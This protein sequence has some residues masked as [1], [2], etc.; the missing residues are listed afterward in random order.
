MPV[1]NLT[2][3]SPWPVWQSLTRRPVLFT[4]CPALVVAFGLPLAFALPFAPAFVMTFPLVLCLG[5]MLWRPA[6]ALPLA[7]FVGPLV[8]IQFELGLEEKTASFDKLLLVVI[9]GAWAL[10]KVCLR[11][12]NVPQDSLLVLWWSWLAVL[13][14][15]VALTRTHLGNQLWFMAEQLSYLLFFAICLDVLRDPLALR[16]SVQAIVASG[17][18]VVLLGM[19]NWVG[20]MVG[21]G[22]IPLTYP[23]TDEWLYSFVSTIGQPNFYSAYQ[24][25][26][27]PVA[28]WI[29]WNSHGARRWLFGFL[30][31]LQVAS[32]IRAQSFG[33]GVGLMVAALVAWLLGG[34]RNWKRA[35]C[36]FAAVILLVAVWALK[37]RDTKWFDRSFVIRAHILSVSK[38]IFAE[39]PLFGHGLSSFTRIFPDYETVYARERLVGELGQWRAFPRSISSHN[40]FLRLGVEGGLASLLA[41][42]ALIGWVI[43][44]RWS[45]LRS[46]PLGIQKRDGFL[47]L[48][49]WSFR[50]ALMASLTGFVF[51]AVTEELFA[52][53]KV[54]L[55]FWAL[56]AVGVILDKR[57]G[58][59]NAR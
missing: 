8:N 42:L 49:C 45:S 25:L 1:S 50:L 37:A 22:G 6:A 36:V 9:V 5:C 26:C 13:G 51:Q 3:E 31:L 27:I 59:Q 11:D 56:T 44:S 28:V 46:P 17:W 30:V 14:V 19:G 52:Y 2:A 55:V 18:V 57:T 24:I 35:A 38:H 58:G 39:R 53:S 10:R 40:W 33:G 4:V 7:L 20:R 48:D 34:G 41:F 43:V 29:F 54:V 47:A 32:V 21:L 15:T 12:R 16:A 23:S